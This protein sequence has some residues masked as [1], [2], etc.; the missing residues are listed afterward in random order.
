MRREEAFTM[1][2]VMMSLVLLLFWSFVVIPFVL[3]G[4]DQIRRLQATLRDYEQLQVE[5]LHATDEDAEEA[6][7]RCLGVACLPTR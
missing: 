5:V 1:W 2:E 7:Q 3:N 4:H 6:Q